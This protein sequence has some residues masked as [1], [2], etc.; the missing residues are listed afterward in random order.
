M[1]R[2]VDTKLAQYV[3]RGFPPPSAFWQTG[4]AL[5]SRLERSRPTP[6][7]AAI[8]LLIDFRT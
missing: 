1:A 8:L 7:N 5:K 3:G 2:V 4:W 6:T